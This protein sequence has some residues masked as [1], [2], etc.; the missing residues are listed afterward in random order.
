MKTRSLYRNSNEN[1]GQTRYLFIKENIM[2]NITY[3]SLENKLKIQQKNQHFK[4]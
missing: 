1:I 2:Y 4:K 3:C